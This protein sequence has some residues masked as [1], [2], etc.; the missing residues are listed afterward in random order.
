MFNCER[1]LQVIFSQFFPEVTEEN[2]TTKWYWK[3]TKLL[4]QELP[5]RRKMRWETKVTL[6]CVVNTLCF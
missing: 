2:K 5:Q 4:L 6:P 1:Y 3:V